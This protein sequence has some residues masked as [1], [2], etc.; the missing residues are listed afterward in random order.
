MQKRFLSLG[1]GMPNSRDLTVLRIFSEDP[2]QEYTMR[3]MYDRAYGPTDQLTHRQKVHS[4]ERCFWRLRDLGFIRKLPLRRKILKPINVRPSSAAVY[5][6]TLEGLDYLR[7]Y[8]YL[9]H[10]W[11]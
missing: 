10:T 3:D 4:M 2:D 9:L 11:R 6:V 7:K 1:R 8:R 5:M